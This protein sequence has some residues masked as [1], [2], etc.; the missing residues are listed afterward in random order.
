MHKELEEID[1]RR[2]CVVDQK[3]LNGTLLARAWLDVERSLAPVKFQ[4]F[5]FDGTELTE[6]GTLGILWR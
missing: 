4:S 2:C 5:E 3:R 1:G 6:S